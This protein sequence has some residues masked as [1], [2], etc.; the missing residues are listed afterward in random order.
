MPA[1]PIREPG[2]ARRRS[3]AAITAWAGDESVR[4][5]GIRN[6]IHTIA[7]SSK[8][9]SRGMVYNKHVRQDDGESQGIYTLSKTEE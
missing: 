8:V 2:T 6:C 7:R 5:C 4:E 1:R 3:R 9:E